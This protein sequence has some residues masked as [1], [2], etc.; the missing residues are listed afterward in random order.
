MVERG[1]PLVGF[2]QVPWKTFAFA[3]LLLEVCTV[4]ASIITDRV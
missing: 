4:V 1:D 2:L 3:L